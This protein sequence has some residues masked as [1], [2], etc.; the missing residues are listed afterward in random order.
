MYG[1]PKIHKIN[2]P[3]I[4]IISSSGSYSYQLSKYFAELI[5]NNRTSLSFS[6]IRDSFEF[7]RKI[8]GTNNSK[9]QIMIS[10]DVDSLHTN[11]PVHEAIDITL[12]MLFKK[13]ISVTYT[14]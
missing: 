3:L 14:F 12:D 5:K 6:Y 7:V 11:I 10:F 1:Q 8:C 9:N 4:P 13:V 2:Y